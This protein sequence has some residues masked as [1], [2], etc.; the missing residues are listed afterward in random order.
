MTRR[1]ANLLGVIACAGLMAYALYSQHVLG[2]EPCPLCVFQRVGVIALGCVFLLAALHNPG[3]GARFVYVTGVLIAAGA[4][5]GVAG[6]HV[7][8]Q[9]LPADQVP[10]CGASLDFLLETTPFFDVLRQVFTGSG[11]C[12]EVDWVFLGLSMP[13]WVIVAAAGLGLAGVWANSA[14]PANRYPSH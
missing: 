12:A 1:S 14:L 9:N 6:R 11:E 13:V 5:V 4:T 3:G 2:Y 10:A 8:L 7:Y